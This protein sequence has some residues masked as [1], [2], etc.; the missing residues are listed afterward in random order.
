MLSFGLFE[1][2]VKNVYDFLM[3]DESD[4]GCFTKFGILKLFEGD[5]NWFEKMF[6]TISIEND[7][8]CRAFAA[9]F[10]FTGY[11]TYIRTEQMLEKKADDELLH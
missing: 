11:I 1:Y 2:E 7:I 3:E 5:D 10:L 4:I 8:E 9:Y 6:E